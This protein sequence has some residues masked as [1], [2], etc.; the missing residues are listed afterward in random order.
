MSKVVRCMFTFY[1]S[2]F[3]VGLCI[4]LSCVWLYSI[5][6]NNSIPILC[7]YKAITVAIFFY[8]VNKYKSKEFFYYQN[9]GISKQILWSVTLSIDAI[10]FI[11]LMVFTNNHYYA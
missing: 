2:H 7:W 3:F 11:A 8:S 6:G 1:S 10:L 5:L 9:L 4:T